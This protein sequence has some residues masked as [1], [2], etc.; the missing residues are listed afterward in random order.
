MARKGTVRDR[1]DSAG[2]L[3]VSVEA[4]WYDR[5]GARRGKRFPLDT[6]APPNSRAHKRATQAATDFLDRTS[7]DKQRGSEVDPNARERF[8]QVAEDWYAGK[9]GRPKTVAGYRS[10]LDKHVL[11]RFGDLP[12]NRIM[13]SEIRSWLKDMATATP[14]E[15]PAAANTI[16]NAFLVARQ[17]F[18][19]AVEN[20]YIASNPAAR[21][22]AR[23]LPHPYS[24]PPEMLFLTAEEVCR[25][26]AA[27]DAIHPE[28]RYGTLI[29]FAAWTGMRS[30]EIAGLRARNLDLLRGVVHVRESLSE[31]QGHLHEV[32]PKTGKDR[33]I[34][35]LAPH[36]PR[37][38]AYL[39]SQPAKA[40][41]DFV[42]TS[43]A[44]AQLRHVGWFYS[45]VFKPAVRAAALPSD[46]RFHDLR[47]TAVA[48][49]VADGWHPLAISRRLGHSSITVTMDR[50]G[51]LLPALEED[52]LA[53]SAE[54]FTRAL[55]TPV[56][57][58]PPLRRIGN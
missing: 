13:T 38:R 47:H 21:I 57:A 48:L 17:V 30:G 58:A 28:L 40:P 23:D 53:R 34:P 11:P 49:L 1:L 37:L 9:S 52:L 39:D 45:N 26:Q 10:L 14:P 35:L 43:P 3:I 15:H 2:S 42:F 44:G 32:R 20:G 8:K 31:V 4:R 16:R 5:K 27:A 50:Y 36:V 22:P 7:A 46:L 51:H 33:T 56:D 55:R 6:P 19:I 54:S 41:G 25:L 29:E 18:N 24:V 12:V